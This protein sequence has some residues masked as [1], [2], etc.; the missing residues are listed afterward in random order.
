METLHD[1]VGDM[2]RPRGELVDVA[3][4]MK[5]RMA[6]LDTWESNVELPSTQMSAHKGD[7]GIQGVQTQDMEYRVKKLEERLEQMERENNVL[8][9][10][11]RGI[12]VLQEKLRLAEEK[13]IQLQNQLKE[14]KSQR[15]NKID[16]TVGQAL[17]EEHKSCEGLRKIIEKTGQRMFINGRKYDL[18]A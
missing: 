3:D 6:K 12:N 4:R 7:D 14:E 2:Y 1:I 17:Y 8:K 18:E 13:N 10:K 16:N 5:A 15:I 11:T 9:A